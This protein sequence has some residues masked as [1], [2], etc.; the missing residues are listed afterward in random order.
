MFGF[1]T[2]QKWLVSRRINLRKE[3]FLIDIEVKD[4][5]RH[6]SASL[7]RWS[8]CT[9]RDGDAWGIRLNFRVQGLRVRI[10]GLGFR[11]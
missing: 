7:A 5:H 10:E 8:G 11:V 4:V 9:T 2:R 6:A 1:V 3:L